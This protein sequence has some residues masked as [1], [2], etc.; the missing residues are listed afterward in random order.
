MSLID[1]PRAAFTLIELLVVIAI[2]AILA[3][4]LFPVF[5][6]A[7]EKARQTTCLSNLKQVGAC[8]S[9]YVMDHEAYPQ[10]SSP[11]SQVPRTRWPDTIWPY[12]RSRGIFLCPSANPV[13]YAKG[14][15]HDPTLT[16]GG[17]GYNFEYLGNSRFP[18]NA[19]DA[20]I[21]A[22]AQT[23]ALADSWGVNGLPGVGVTGGT[24]G[25]YVIDPPLTCARGTRPGGTD[26]TGYG[27]G[28]ECGGPWHCRGIL[29]ERH[30]ELVNVAFCDGHAKALRLT[31]MD[32]SNRDGQLDN[33]LWNGVGDPAVR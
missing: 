13:L 11:G 18:F 28:A 33:G 25:Q 21:A 5:A 26:N 20:Q 27:A 4:I 7:R 14:F 31:A 8:L 23:I 12:A 19:S 24:A 10:M 9:Q 2:L 30:N 22:P 15:A 29:A 3:A 17:Y 1:R 6:K 16:Y 32:D